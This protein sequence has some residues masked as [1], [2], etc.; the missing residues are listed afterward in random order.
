MPPFANGP[1]TVA[2]VDD[3]DVVV[4]GARWR[5]AGPHREGAPAM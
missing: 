4:L 3:Y 1:N 2:L 5:M